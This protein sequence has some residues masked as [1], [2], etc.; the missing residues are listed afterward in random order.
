MPRDGVDRGPWWP[1]YGDPT[2]DRPGGA[3]RHL[4]PDPDAG[5]E[6]AYRRARAMVRQ[7]AVGAL[8]HDLGQR[9]L[10]PERHAAAAAARRPGAP[11][12]DATLEATRRP[13][14]RPAP[15]LELGD[16]PVGP[17]AP[18]GRER[19]GGGAGQRRRS[20]QCAA[21]G[22][23]RS[24]RSNYFS[25]RISERSQAGLPGHRSA[26]Y[27]RSVEIVQNQLDAGIVS[28]ES[29]SRRRRP[30]SSRR[31]RQLVAENINRATFEHAVADPGRQRRRR[32][33][34]RRARP[35]LAG[36]PTVELG[37]ALDACWSGGPTSPR[38]SARWR[39]P[40]PRSAWPG[41]AYY[42]QHLARQRR[43]TLS[44]QQPELR[45]SRSAT[46]CGRSARRSPAR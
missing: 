33:P 7:D 28:R 38:P 2:L 18:P 37:D 23:D 19:S 4:Q 43:S 32:R 11:S 17:P 1:M 25:M 30:S 3:D 16:R 46:R 27:P 40:M 29:T 20:R 21:V 31:A 41:A 45:C 14:H 9:R 35:Q 39:R 34:Q 26:A 6:A 10:H 12:I 13:V 22:A 44:R 15:T 8:S 36:V 24:W 5:F 42:P